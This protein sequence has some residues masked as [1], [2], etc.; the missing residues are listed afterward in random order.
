MPSGAVSGVTADVAS[1]TPAASG[2]KEAASSGP[3][4]SASAAQRTGAATLG[5]QLGS[6]ANTTVEPQED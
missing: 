1:S 2:A 4:A 6:S 5:G 3:A